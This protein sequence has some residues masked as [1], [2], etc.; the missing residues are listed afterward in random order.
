MQF[1]AK[2]FQ[3]GTPILAGAGVRDGA[4]ERLGHCLKPVADPEHRDAELEH[5]GIELRSPIGVDTGRSAG[6]HERQRITGSDLLD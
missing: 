5:R 4:A 1:A 3:F 2:D 6:Q